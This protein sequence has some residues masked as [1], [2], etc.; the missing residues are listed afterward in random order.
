MKVEVST[1]K[2]VADTVLDSLVNA[3]KSGL[4]RH[5]KR[6]TRAEVHLKNVEVE[7]RARLI[8]CKLEVRP[9]SHDP[10]VVRHEAASLDEVVKAAAVKMNRLLESLFARLDSTRGGVSASGLPT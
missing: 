6:L 7:V 4:G 5:E 9:A 10:V 3:V 2:P 1:D 8:E